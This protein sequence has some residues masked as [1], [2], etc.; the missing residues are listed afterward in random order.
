LFGAPYDWRLPVDALMASTNLLGTNNTFETDLR[1]LIERAY[2]VSGGKRV[3]IVTHSLGG[4]TILYFL[5]KRTLAWKTQYVASFVPIAGPFAGALKSLRAMI[6]GDNMGMQIPILNWS[7]LSEAQIARNFRQSGSTA[8]IAPDYDYYGSQVFVETPTKNY[9]A[10]DF[11]Q[12][13]TDLGSPISSEIWNRS[14]V[15]KCFSFCSI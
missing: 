14:K 1:L 6:S 4:P 11:G 9:T 3:H 7:L 13:F 8:Y 5:N 12:M 15:R 10:S 2:N